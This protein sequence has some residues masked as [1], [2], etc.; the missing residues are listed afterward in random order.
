MTKVELEEYVTE[1]E[2]AIEDALEA[3]EDGNRDRSREI[4]SEY[5]EDEAE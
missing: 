2:R 3:L 1:L 4:L 5:V